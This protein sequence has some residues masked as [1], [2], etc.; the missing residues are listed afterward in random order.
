[1]KRRTRRNPDRWRAD[2]L[3]EWLTGEP[4]QAT[5]NDEQFPLPDKGERYTIGDL[6]SITRALENRLKTFFDTPIP[7]R[8]RE[9]PP[10]L[11]VTDKAAAKKIKQQCNTLAEMFERGD[12][13]SE[14]SAQVNTE[15]N[16]RTV[17]D[18]ET[19]ACALD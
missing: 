9:L 3:Q 14:V 12:T 19:A 5:Q 16:A 17:V 11:N 8:L 1:M 10:L 13:P 18:V 15:T 6:D 4:M 7:A 2:H